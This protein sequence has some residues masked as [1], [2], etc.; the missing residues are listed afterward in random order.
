MRTI[1]IAAVTAVML[2]LAPAPV[3]SQR[4]GGQQPELVR[5]GQQLIRRGQLH[6][7]LAL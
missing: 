5:E 7:A 1:S 2:V 4:G 6:E 3:A